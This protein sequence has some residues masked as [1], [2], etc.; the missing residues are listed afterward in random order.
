M[1]E[2]EVPGYI[3]DTVEQSAEHLREEIIREAYAYRNNRSYPARITEALMSLGRA[4]LCLRD[5]LSAG[6]ETEL[7]LF[8]EDEGV[9]VSIPDR[10]LN[11]NELGSLYLL[12]DTA[13]GFQVGRDIGELS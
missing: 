13:W 3:R 8:V 1:S 10:P 9:R 11:R 12:V 2:P 7:A 4:A 5:P 6:A